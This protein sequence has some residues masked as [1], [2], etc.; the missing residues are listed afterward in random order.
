MCQHFVYL[1]MFI[2][3]VLE[4]LKCIMLISIPFEIPALKSFFKTIL[5]VHSTFFSYKPHSSPKYFAGLLLAKNFS[6]LSYF[7]YWF[8]GNAHTLG[9]FWE[10][11][12][13]IWS[14]LFLFLNACMIQ[15][16]LILLHTNP[17]TSHKVFQ[18]YGNAANKTFIKLKMSG[19]LSGVLSQILYKAK[20]METFR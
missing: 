5:T 15:R 19:E 1:D 14:N 6:L 12:V 7:R 20:P 16:K 4:Y 13:H 8:T 18:G 11:V 9:K 10:R 3:D 2:F 17:A